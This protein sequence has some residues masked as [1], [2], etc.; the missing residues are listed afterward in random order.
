[1]MDGDDERGG[2]DGALNERDIPG[3]SLDGK[4]PS[5]LTVPQLKRWLLYRKAPTKADLVSRLALQYKSESELR[6][7]IISI[8]WL[9]NCPITDTHGLVRKVLYHT[10]VSHFAQ[11]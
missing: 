10:F 4:K 9:T 1:M 6:A 11:S 8:S 5:D 3:A 7:Y 2:A